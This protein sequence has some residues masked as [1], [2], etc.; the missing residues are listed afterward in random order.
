[1]NPITIPY[2]LILPAFI[3][4]IMLFF[5]IF[6]PKKSIKKSEKRW[7][8]ISCI[9][10]ISVYFLIIGSAAFEDIHAQIILNSFDLD[11]DGFFSEIEST[12]EQQKAMSILLND[13]G[14]NFSFITGLIIS[15]IV[16][17]PIY[18]IGRSS[19]RNRR[20]L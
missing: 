13:T 1:M 8:R 11:G 2:H 10:F 15:L 20:K 9:I 18:L 16:S 12:Y 3:C 4:L 14:R 19:E 6:K 17:L 5:L 7:F